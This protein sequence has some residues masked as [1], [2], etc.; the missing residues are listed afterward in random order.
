MTACST[1]AL[2]AASSPALAESMKMIPPAPMSLTH[3]QTLKTSNPELL[4]KLTHFH[5]VAQAPQALPVAN[6]VWRPLVHQPSFAAMSP[7]LLSDGSVLV[8]DANGSADGGTGESWYK[9]TPNIE[10]SYIAGTWTKLAD[11]QAGYTPLYTA[12]AL[13]PDGRVIIEGGEYINGNAVWSGQ[14]SIYDP[15]ADSWSAVAPPAG[16]AMTSSIGDA[17]GIVLA[18]GTFML[19]PVYQPA[20]GPQQLFNAAKLTWT[21]TGLNNK[22]SNDEDSQALTRGDNILTTASYNNSKVG[23]GAELYDAKTG[24]WVVITKPPVQLWDKNGEI[25]PEVNM[26]NGAVF[27]FGSTLGHTAILNGR[28]W[29]IGP[30]MPIIGGQR[31]GMADAPATVLPSGKI[32]AMGGP[33]Y[34]ATPSHFFL[35][36]G[37]TFT[38]TADTPNAPG[39]SNFQGNM[40][41]LPTGQ[42]LL[43]DQS[44]DIEIYTDPGAP[45]AGNAPKGISV[46]TTLSTGP[47]FTLKG[48]QLGGTTQGAAYGDDY[49]SATNYPIVRI[50]NVATKHVFYARTF[51]FSTMAITPNAAS[52]ASFT[53]PAGIE[54]G[55]SKLEV[56]ASG[57]ASAPVAVTVTK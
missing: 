12:S 15:V 1:L 13:L 47:I 3:Y 35:Y 14:G 37:K 23:V 50:I 17:S 2:L 18:D 29:T 49:Q 27:A 43:T 33:G 38:Q 34:A 5:A 9:L 21:A 31:Y 24:K 46:P 10:G 20:S 40:L 42:I 39:D 25:G 6:S 11:M 56:I 51:G 19:S 16:M 32:L 8:G 57:F 55:A 7:L 41:V 54:T 22:I 52:T 48:S 36:D 30:D 28:T 45:V 4:Q 44:G 26:L 53:L